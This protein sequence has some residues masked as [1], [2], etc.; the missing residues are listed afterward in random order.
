[1]AAVAIVFIGIAFTAE[2]DE[3][4]LGRPVHVSYHPAASVGSSS[5]SGPS[6]TSSRSASPASPSSSGPTS[7]ASPPRHTQ[8]AGATRV[9][10]PPP[11]SAGEDDPDEDDDYYDVDSDFDDD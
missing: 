3:A 6:T 9:T 8:N 1:M 10:E 11:P 4:R 7:V 2:A 5:P